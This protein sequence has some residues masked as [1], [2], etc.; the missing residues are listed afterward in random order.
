MQLQMQY[1]AERAMEEKKALEEK[2]AMEEEKAIEDMI[3][4]GE[5][6]SFVHQL[7]ALSGTHESM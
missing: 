7:R 2:R 5:L 6:S 3:T 1:E 4:L